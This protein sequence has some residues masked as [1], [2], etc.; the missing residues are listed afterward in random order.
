MRAAFF[1]SLVDAGLRGAVAFMVVALTNFK[2]E[3]MV[4]YTNTAA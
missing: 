4:T 3:L 1:V 2:T